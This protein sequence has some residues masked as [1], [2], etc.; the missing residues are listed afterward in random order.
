MTAAERLEEARNA[1]HD[2][3][4][5]TSV[6]EVTDQNG[7]KIRYRTIDYAKLA[8]YV[9]DLEAEVAGTSV[10]VRPMRLWGR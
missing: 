6:A 1:L 7:E 4:T 9:K 3:N 8:A 10:D 2:L 5:G